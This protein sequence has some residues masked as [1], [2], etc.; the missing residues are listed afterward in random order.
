MTLTGVYGDSAWA[1]D[2]QAKAA[3]SVP[4]QR[5]G[6]PEELAHAIVFLQT[7][8]FVT[9]VTIDVDGGNLIKA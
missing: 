2:Y 7:N 4:L 9:G 3:A 1:K 6:L 8:T 5:N